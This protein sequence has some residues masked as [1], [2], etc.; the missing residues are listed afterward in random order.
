MSGARQGGKSLALPGV[1]GTARALLLVMVAATLG[2][3]TADAADPR[4]GEVKSKPCTTCHGKDGI[5][6]MPMIPNLAGQKSIY[7]IQQLRGFRDGKRS[8]EVMSIVVRSLSDLD[9][10]DL[11]AFYESLNP[12]GAGG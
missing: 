7:L 2:A 8:S 4:A 10:E 3:G 12:A 5:G 1:R 11:A 9:I 6:T